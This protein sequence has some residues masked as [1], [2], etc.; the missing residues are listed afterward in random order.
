LLVT[1][2]DPHALAD[3]LR[4]LA[5]DD[6]LRATIAAQGRRVYAERASRRVLG[7]LWRQAL[8]TEPLP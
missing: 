4:L 6:Q 3:A 2:E 1:P 7:A 5:A 8:D